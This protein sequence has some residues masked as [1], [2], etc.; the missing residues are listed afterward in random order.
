[1]ISDFLKELKEFFAET[2]VAG[3][4]EYGEGSSAFC[5]IGQVPCEFGGD[6]GVQDFPNPVCVS[7]MARGEGMSHSDIREI[8]AIMEP[9][10]AIR[11]SPAV[12]I[13][14]DRSRIA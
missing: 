3:D 4:C 11:L 9:L 13:L 5:G 7:K 1:M 8:E 12:L 6:C 14:T 2:A 10:F